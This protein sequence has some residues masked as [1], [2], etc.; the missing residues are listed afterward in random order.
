MEEMK[1]LYNEEAMLKEWTSALYELGRLPGKQYIKGSQDN[2]IQEIIDHVKNNK[3]RLH[4]K[5]VN[6]QEGR[7][8]SYDKDCTGD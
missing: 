3:H 6:G 8:C 2:F 7:L 5:H 4:V 1:Q